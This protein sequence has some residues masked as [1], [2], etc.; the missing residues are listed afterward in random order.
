MFN[1]L[2]LCSKEVAEASIEEI[3]DTVE[4]LGLDGEDQYLSEPACIDVY[5]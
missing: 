3:A 5:E 4:D 2:P 1:R